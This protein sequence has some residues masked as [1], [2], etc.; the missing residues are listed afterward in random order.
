M[1]PIPPPPVVFISY[2][3]GDD[4]LQRLVVRLEEDL[5]SSG[6]VVLVDTNRDLASD[7]PTT[8]GFSTRA[9]HDADWILCICSPEYHKK[10]NDR[11]AHHWLFEEWQAITLRKKE[12]PPER[13]VPL[14]GSGS[15]YKDSCPLELQPFRTRRDFRNEEN[16]PSEFESLLKSIAKVSPIS[17]PVSGMGTKLILVADVDGFS[18]M[19]NDEQSHIMAKIWPLLGKLKGNLGTAGW[20]AEFPIL[21]GFGLIW[22]TQN[23]H[24]TVVDTAKK[25]GEKVLRKD[26]T[27]ALRFG[28]EL[29]QV[30]SSSVDNILMPEARH[31]FGTGINDAGRA[32]GFGTAGQVIMTDSFWHQA[33]RS[34]HEWPEIK[35]V[36]PGRQLDE[37]IVIF[38][39]RGDSGRIRI[40]KNGT[41][42][43]SW[44]IDLKRLAQDRFRELMRELT[45]EFVEEL[46]EI[47]T[48]EIACE[49][50]RATF[51]FPAEPGAKELWFSRIRLE[52]RADPSSGEGE[53]L[54]FPDWDMVPCH[55][56]SSICY[57]TSDGGEGPPGMAWA[58]AAEGKAVVAHDLPCDSPEEYSR[59]LA[60]EFNLSVERTNDFSRRSS[61]I[62][63]C[64]FPIPLV[65]G[66][67][68]PGVIC[69]D[70]NVIFP[71]PVS[72]AALESLLFELMQ[73]YSTDLTLAWKFR[74]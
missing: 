26:G 43:R 21:D 44:R 20:E 51:W 58:G 5:K 68:A 45:I 61:L 25:I 13:V 8:A 41:Q 11:D 40:L 31:Y 42:N 59:K 27:P 32:G 4:H 56:E 24:R 15:T 71:T 10:I 35:N 33:K 64:A 18:E 73:G 36:W 50:V 2:A 34:E 60:E 9:P 47:H 12:L 6:C 7:Y 22:D 14:W 67:D 57:S 16:Y 1:P 52:G 48:A 39:L 30:G 19:S 3:H 63:A 29:G 54:L 70:M 55:D 69:L 53:Q 62:G 23:S 37:G 66:M 28:L 46:R 72:R 65:N 49:S 38:P 74:I 17:K